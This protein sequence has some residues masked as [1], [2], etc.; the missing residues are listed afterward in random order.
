MREDLDPGGARPDE[1]DQRVDACSRCHR[2]AFPVLVAHATAA[3][4][5]CLTDAEQRMIGVDG[6]VPPPL[7]VL[8]EEPS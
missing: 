6:T 5:A 8:A 1:W 7:V 3:C 2:I 4:W